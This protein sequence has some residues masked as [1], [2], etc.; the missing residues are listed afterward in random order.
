[1]ASLA[2]I[3]AKLQASENNQGNNRSSGGDNAIYA[4]WNIQEGTS[5]TIRFLQTQ[6]QTT[7][8]FG[9]NEI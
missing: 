8:S 3:R 5:A 1:M 7:H 6:I 2:D 4:H 9:K